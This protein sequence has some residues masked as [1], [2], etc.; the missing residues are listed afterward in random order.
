MKR[1]QYLLWLSGIAILAGAIKAW[2][3]LADHVPFNADEAVV[4][5]MARHI[6]Q[7]EFPIFFYGQ[8]YLGSLDA[9]LVAG[10]F[11]L[12]GERVWVI[13]LLQGLLYA[14][15]IVTT[16]ALGSRIIGTKKA[17]LLSG[18]L[19]AVPTVNVA[20]YTTVSLGG[21]GEALLIG[22]LILLLT[23]RIGN[24][25]DQGLPLGREVLWALWGALAGLG[26]WV[27]GLTLVYILPAGIILFYKLIKQSSWRHSL[28]AVSAAGVGG[29]IGSV[30][31]WIYAIQE[32]GSDLMME[33]TGSAIAGATQAPVLLKPLIH[34]YHFLLFG[35]TVIFG[36][37]PPWGVEWLMLPLA[38]F[39]ILL[40]FSVSLHMVQSV[41]TS[42]K[43]KWGKSLLL[44]VIG[45]TIMGFILTPFGADPSGRYFL[46][47]APFLA[48]FAAD[49]ILSVAEKSPRLGIGVT[50]FLLIFNAGGILQSIH[51]TPHGL[52]TQFDPVARV[53]H[54]Y[55]RELIDFLLD[56]DIKRGY[57]NYWV[58]Y[59]LAFKSREEL[60]FV[61]A[62]PYHH[63][64][65]YTSRDNRYQPYQAMV[66]RSSTAAYITTN[67]QPLNRYLRQKFQEHDVR[68]SEK[69]IGDYRVFFAMDRKIIPE[70]IG[71]G[72]TN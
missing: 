33:L 29:V 10:G 4:A 21:Y 67:H 60:I 51:S 32:G 26:L 17:G 7:G 45:V 25:L 3:V 5:L 46:P 1:K 65:R 48:L 24:D 18:L 57:T 62:L 69:T 58:A 11:Q 42:T 23:L 2:L 54:D 39:A 12:F 47:L 31:W 19:L 35:I 16:A 66:D 52:T 6:T 71:L 50:V 44:S 28:Q 41:R 36:L 43:N 59:P 34:T 63:D 53:N 56:E 27:F 72:E 64:F 37:R 15:T 40:W 70:E 22:N 38:P 55:D 68:W 9:L 8:S 49:Y 61:P 14:G 30:P 20:L 13:R